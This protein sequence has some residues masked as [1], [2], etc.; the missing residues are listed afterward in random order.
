MN[1]ARFRHER[2]HY[3]VLAA[4]ALGILLS[5]AGLVFAPRQLLA[6]WWTA[7][8]FVIGLPI[9]AATILLIHVLTGGKWGDAVREP[10]RAVTATMPLAILILLP[11]TIGLSSA[12]PWAGEATSSLPESVQLKLAYLNVPFFLIR[13]AICIAVWLVVCW[14]A[15]DATAP[16]HEPGRAHGGRAQLAALGLGINALAVAVFSTD[17]MLA[18]EPEFSSTIYAML[19]LSGE[20]V[21]AFALAGLIYLVAIGP[22]IPEG[23][24]PGVLITEDLSN[25]MFGFVLTWVYLAF[26]QYLIIWAGDLP[27]EIHW[28]VT[29]GRDGWQY[30]LWLR[31]LLHAA[32]PIAA[33]LARSL[34]RRRETFAA[35]FLMLF[36]AHWLDVLWRVRPAFHETSLLGSWA[37][38]GALLAVCGIYAAG[39]LYVLSGRARWLER[40]VD[41]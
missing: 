39:L 23:G 17:W 41:G 13:F 5:I 6:G 37:D 4:L 21:G 10:L 18:L 11:L 36:V 25:M 12:F 22:E 38:L 3:P 31:I 14:I 1:T 32:L 16:R 28:Y 2:F 40:S 30:V 7:G 27:S 19:E 15:L 33:F 34:K 24:S 35:I 8:L 20:T 29:R 26:M 9:G